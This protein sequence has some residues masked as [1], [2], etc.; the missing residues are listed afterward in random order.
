MLGIFLCASWPSVCL[1]GEMSIKIFCPV[2]NWVVYFLFL[3]CMSCLYILEIEPLSVT[4]FANIFCISIDCPLHFIL[5]MAS[6]TVQ[7]QSLII[8]N[9][10]IFVFIYIALGDWQYN[11]C[12]NVLPMISSKSLMMSCLM[13]K[14]LRHFE[15]IF[16]Q[17]MRVCSNFIDLHAAVQLSQHHLL[18]RLS[19]LY[20]VFLPHLSEINWP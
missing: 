14:S 4:S 18:K 7:K 1:L 11:L 13:F 9:L 20:C 17:D 3:S 19:F 5:F 16:V 12:Q 2:F 15:F 6:F 10:F 8:S